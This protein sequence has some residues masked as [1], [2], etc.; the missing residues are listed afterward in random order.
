MADRYYAY[1]V[2]PND[3]QTRA[4]GFVLAPNKEEALA[5]A[6]LAVAK[7]RRR[8]AKWLHMRVAD[9]PGLARTYR[10]RIWLDE[11]RASAPTAKHYT[12]KA[13]TA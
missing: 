6:K 12:E 9:L 5:K 2:H 10:V 8:I 3:Y 13:R 11:N 4:R 1:C 7:E